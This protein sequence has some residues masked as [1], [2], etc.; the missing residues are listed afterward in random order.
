MIKNFETAEEIISGIRNYRQTK[1][2]SPREAVEVYTG[3]SGFE[4]EAV[5]RKLA[6]VADIHFGEKQISQA[7]RF[8]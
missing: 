4:N 7:L 6:N 2:I 3:A 1:G 8:W 5:I